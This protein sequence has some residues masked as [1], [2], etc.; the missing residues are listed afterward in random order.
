MANLSVPPDLALLRHEASELLRA[1][2]DGDSRALARFGVGS[3]RPTHA[4]AQG[5]VACE[6]GFASWPELEREVERR[7]ILDRAGTSRKH[8]EVEAILGPPTNAAADP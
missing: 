1:A 5:V 2:L 7:V 3:A 6:H 8:R 4:A